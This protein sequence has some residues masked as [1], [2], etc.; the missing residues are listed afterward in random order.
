MKDKGLFIVLEGTDGSGK[1]VQSAVLLKHLQKIGYRCEIVDFPQY[2]QSSAFFVEEYLNGKYGGWKE[3]G[4]K[5]ASLFYALDRYD[6][7]KKVRKALGRGRIVL[8]NRYV[9]SNM[10]HQGAKI[11]TSAKKKDFFKWVYDLE[12][13]ILGIPRPDLN[14]FLHVPAQIAYHLIWKKE[15]RKYLHGK[16]RDVHEKDLRHLYE[17]EKSY[18]TALKLFPRD[19]KMI[20]CV[21]VDKLLT[22]EEIALKIWTIVQKY[23]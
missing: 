4:P 13:N 9:A 21:N 2:G 10:G 20:N 15:K 22:I 11:L 12:Y 23:L 5:R 8:A 3:V 17:A 6:V 16:K 18:L 1:A 14:I 7:A 19:F